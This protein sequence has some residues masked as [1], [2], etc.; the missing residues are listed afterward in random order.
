[1]LKFKRVYL[2]LVLLALSCKEVTK[3]DNFD[4]IEWQRD[5]NGCMGIRKKM[6]ESLEK[7]SNK[8]K[9]LSQNQVLQLLGKPDIH[10]LYQRQQR[11]YVYFVEKG[12][13]CDSLQ[14]PAGKSLQVRF[15]AL[16]K[17]SELFVE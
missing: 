8:L 3:L 4:R 12:I 1:M 11:F 16:D 5:K 9:D 14:F 7:Q 15:S 2:L 17:V 10:N 6:V 13:Q